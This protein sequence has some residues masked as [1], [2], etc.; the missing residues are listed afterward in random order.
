MSFHYSVRHFHTEE[1]PC[2]NALQQRRVQRPKQCIP[3]SYQATL[4]GHW[5]VMGLKTNSSH[6]DTRLSK[7]EAA[8]YNI[9]SLADVG[10]LVVN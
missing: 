3:S 2:Q 8:I 6:V 1:E 7:M 10:N 5:L 4:T 9:A